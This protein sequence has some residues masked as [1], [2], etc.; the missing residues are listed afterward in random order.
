MDYQFEKITLFH[1][2]ILKKNKS[3]KSV[4]PQLVLFHSIFGKV[5]PLNHGS[6]ATESWNFQLKT[7]S[8]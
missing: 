6:N 7:K 5:D 4:I 2:S 8:D 1:K 3:E